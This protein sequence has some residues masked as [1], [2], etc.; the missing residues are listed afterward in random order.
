M[1]KKYDKFL[2]NERWLYQKYWGEELSIHKIA[3]VVGCS[4]NAIMLALKRYSIKRRTYSE[5]QKHIKNF[6]GKHH[7]EET[8]QKI[9]E[10]LKDKLTG[11]KHPF[12]G[13]HHS[14]EAIGK[15][16]KALKGKLIGEKNAFFGKHHSEETK[17][18]IREARKHQKP[19]PTHHTN[20]E[21]IFEAICK[22]HD[23]PFKYTGDGSFW[24][25]N[26]NPDFVE[27]NGKKIAVEIFGDYWHSP[28]LR[29]TVSYNQT[30]E[31]RKKVLK[32]YGWKLIVLWESDLKREDAEQFVLAVLKKAKGSI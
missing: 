24:I 3:K 6:L 10:A 25:K 20:P 22:K 27:C 19:F 21:L 4:S 32:K 11:E 18:K 7:T 26:L 5:A 17:Q 1:S 29:N 14:E 31:G 2:R 28:L 23:L 8:K 9:K 16:S 13:K 30:Y 15:I 12:Y